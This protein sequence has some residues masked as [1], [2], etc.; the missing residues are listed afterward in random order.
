MQ[1]ISSGSNRLSCGIMEA[2]G[3]GAA[4]SGGR[5]MGAPAFDAGAAPELARG[6]QG[7]WVTFLQQ[8]LEHH[9]LAPG[10]SGVFDDATEAAV[11]SFQERWQLDPTGQV[12]RATWQ[13]IAGGSPDASVQGGADS[14]DGAGGADGS[15][16]AYD[17]SAGPLTTTLEPTDGG[18][19]PDI[20]GEEHFPIEAT[21]VPQSSASQSWVT[22]DITVTNRSHW[23]LDPV[24]WSWVASVRGTDHFVGEGSGTIG[25]M[26]GYASVS[27][28][29]THEVKAPDLGE[30][31]PIYQ[32]IVMVFST[33]T[34]FHIGSAE[35]VREYYSVTS[36]LMVTAERP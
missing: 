25:R 29:A 32:F 27:L 35:E 7:E 23:T 19:P 20:S 11:H 13:A 3:H 15:A 5:D 28:Q 16:A 33:D 24:T 26:D 30:D 2:A 6:E 9:G 8:W 36:D 31:P 14:A 1:P 21:V 17:G 18:A 4:P 12:D 34:E 22:L 10:A